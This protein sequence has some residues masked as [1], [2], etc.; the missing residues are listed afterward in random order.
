MERGDSW[1]QSAACGQVAHHT[2]D[3]KHIQLLGKCF[4]KLITKYIN[5]I[6]L[7][8]DKTHQP[9]Y[10]DTHI[11]SVHKHR[12]NSMTKRVSQMST[13]VSPYVFVEDTPNA[14]FW[15][16][17]VIFCFRKDNNTVITIIISLNLV[18]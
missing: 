9:H 13:C 3:M 12:T 17:K 8:S 2:I 14:L 7:L 1:L 10:L 4:Q 11:Y 18:Y 6:A 15:V 5:L 16:L